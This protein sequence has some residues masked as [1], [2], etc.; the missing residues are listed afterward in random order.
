MD[1]ADGSTGSVGTER[2]SLPAANRGSGATSTGGGGWCVESDGASCAAGRPTPLVAGPGRRRLRPPRRPRRR[3]EAGRGAAGAG[4][5]AISPAGATIASNV[6]ATSSKGS[7]GSGAATAGEVSWKS[8]DGPAEG[9][10]DGPPGR[11]AA[12][13]AFVFQSARRKRSAAVEYHLAASAFCPS[14]SKKRATSD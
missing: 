8:S 13:C 14:A 2:D 4:E 3:T 9:S 10:P 1:S 6:L 5:A 12:S 7:P 11:A